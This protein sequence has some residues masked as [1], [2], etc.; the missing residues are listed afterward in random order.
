MDRIIYCVFIELG[1]KSLTHLPTYY[2]C[3]SNS[4]VSIAAD[5]ILCPRDTHHNLQAFYEYFMWQGE[6]KVADIIKVANYQLEE[7]WG[8]GVSPIM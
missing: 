8:M 4:F 3:D 5:R 2:G 6:I 1:C 7:K